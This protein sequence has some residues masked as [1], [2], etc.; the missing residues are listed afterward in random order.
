MILEICFEEIEI[1]R[2]KNVEK[3]ESMKRN[4]RNAKVKEGTT[5]K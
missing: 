2:D 1:R 5:N 3:D 4:E